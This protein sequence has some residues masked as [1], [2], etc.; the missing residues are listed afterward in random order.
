MIILMFVSVNALS[1][2]LH[3]FSEGIGDQ[4]DNAFNHG[5]INDEFGSWNE[6]E[7]TILFSNTDTIMQTLILDIDDDGIKELI[8]IDD[9]YI[10]IHGLNATDGVLTSYIEATLNLNYSIIQIQVLKDTDGDDKKEIAVLCDTRFYYLE[11]DG[12]TITAVNDYSSASI[13]R[14]RSSFAC[15]NESGTI[16][17]LI[18]DGA[19]GNNLLE[20]KPF[21][22][23]ASGIALTATDIFITQMGVYLQPPF[24]DI[25]A[26]GDIDVIYHCDAEDD[27]D[28]GEGVCVYDTGINDL[29]ATFSLDNDGMFEIGNNIRVIGTAI[30]QADVTGTLEIIV[31]SVWRAGGGNDEAY[32]TVLR[33]SGL[34]RWEEGTNLDSG[35]ELIHIS[36][37]LIDTSDN[38]FIADRYDPTICY[39]IQEQE[40]TWNRTKIQ[41][42]DGSFG[43]LIFDSAWTAT[44]QEWWHNGTSIMAADT[45]SDGY[46]EIVTDTAILD[47]GGVSDITETNDLSP[48]FFEDGTRDPEHDTF[49]SLTDINDDDMID[50]CVNEY[51]DGVYCYYD[52]DSDNP[53]PSLNR[54]SATSSLFG[55]NY[56][57][58]VCLDS[59]LKISAQEC[60]GVQSC[61][62]E[63]TPLTENEYLVSD[64][65]N[66]S[67]TRIEG[68]E[69]L[70]HPEISCLMDTLGQREITVCLADSSNEPDEDYTFGDESLC[71]TINVIVTNGTA[72]KTCNIPGAGNDAGES[73]QSQDRDDFD[74]SSDDYLNEDD[75]EET[76]GI[77]TNQ[78]PTIKTILCVFFVMMAV[79]ALV[80]RKIHNPFVY[81]MTIILVL[82]ACVKLT[83]ASWNI[84]VMIAILM[85]G[86]IVLYILIGKNSEG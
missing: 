63:N 46:L 58:Y 27:D 62:Y 7:E 43:N 53:A 59:Y 85:S 25:D 29:H 22:D 5:V 55:V 20:Y 17:C 3:S 57:K 33:A 69:S 40:T 16:N 56:G 18:G 65:G 47:I 44:D 41:C 61:N 49:I 70:S 10:Q 84:L 77:F 31:T 60:G 36:N 37:P 15:I 8:D 71:K 75:I 35:T 78:D 11:Y 24:A 13:K 76:I 23:V 28:N 66:G 79:M 82:V 83:L 38:P 50:I 4:F 51:D 48:I 34:E 9:T 1:F 32:I 86:C 74:G 12:T 81:L 68:T 42:R 2:N 30:A 73:S 6:S 39:I 21:T 14:R 80:K 26:D 45:D 64:C 52:G 72:G 67:D 54:S 19:G